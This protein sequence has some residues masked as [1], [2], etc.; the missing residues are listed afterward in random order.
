MT[1]PTLERAARAAEQELGKVEMVLTDPMTLRRMQAK[2]I[3]RAVLMAVRADTDWMH[4]F[5]GMGTAPATFEAICDAILADG[6][7]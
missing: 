5:D 7:E 1:N 3:A 2:R 4:Q 6:G